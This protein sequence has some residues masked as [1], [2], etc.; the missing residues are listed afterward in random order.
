M[1]RFLRRTPCAVLLAAQLAG[2]LLYPFLEGSFAGRQLFALFGLLVLG[3]AIFAI[4]ATPLLS[5]V[6][7]LIALPAVVLLVVQVITQNE[8]LAPW[9]SGFEA[10]LYVYAAAAMLAYMLHDDHVTTDELFAIGAVFTLLAWAFAHLYVVVQALDPGSFTAA[11][12]P[13]AARSWTELLFL[14]FTTLSS[15]GLSDVV[16]ISGHSRS[17]VMIEQV[18]GVFYIAMVVTRL[19]A[20]NTARKTQR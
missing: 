2:V 18:A 8:D 15:T 14:S 19:V 1:I 3:L 6:A 11:V 12:D 5:W 17:V 16:P 10:A 20:M 4:R 9:A 7:I 13:D